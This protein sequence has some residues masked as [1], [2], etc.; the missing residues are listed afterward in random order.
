M[1]VT[2]HEIY[3][4]IEKRKKKEEGGIE[5]NRVFFFFWNTNECWFM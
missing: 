5:G 4:G 1:K 3:S 2:S